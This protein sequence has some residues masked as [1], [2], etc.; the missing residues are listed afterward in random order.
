M[1]KR[2]THLTPEERYYIKARLEA[3]DS[4]AEVARWFGRSPSTVSRELKRNTGLLGYRPKQAR[5]GDR[6]TEAFRSSIVEKLREDWSPEQISGRMRLEGGPRVWHDTSHRFVWRDK[7]DGGDRS[8]LPQHSSK[9]RRKRCGKNDFKGPHPGQ[10][11]HLK[12]VRTSSTR[13]PASAGREGDTVVGAGRRG[14]LVTLFRAGPGCSSRHPSP[15]RPRPTPRG[16]CAASPT[17]SRASSTPS[18]TITGA[19]SQTTPPSRVPSAATPASRAPTAAG[20]GG[21]T[22]TGAACS[23]STCPSPCRSTASPTSRSGGPSPGSTTGRASASASKP[24]SRSCKTPRIL[25]KSP[26]HRA[27]HFKV[28]CRRC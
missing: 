9:K 24:P 15:A 18:P 8:A 17:A 14:G 5:R 25:A 22:S 23:A 26:S 4:G 3:G 28:E 13:A 16:P 21:S 6:L 10:A 19:S 12:S 7:R 20:S 2:Y 11:G 1:A 27:L